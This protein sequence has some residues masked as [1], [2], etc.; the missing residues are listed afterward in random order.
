TRGKNCEAMK[1][2]IEEGED[3]IDADAEP[4]VRDAG[5]IAAAQRVEHYKMAAY[6]C[7]QTW[8]RQLGNHAAADLLEHTLH[9]EKETDQKLTQ[10]AES[11]FNLA[12]QHQGY[13]AGANGGSRHRRGRERRFIR[14]KAPFPRDASR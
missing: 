12:A 2:L 13:H 14:R 5:L 9:E 11:M 8:A 7:L 10:R 4:M 6:G 3:M 1:G